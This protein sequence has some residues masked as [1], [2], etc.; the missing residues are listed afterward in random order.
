MNMVNT[1]T[2]VSPFQLHM[3]RSPHVL[4][5]ILACPTTAPTDANTDTSKAQQVLDRIGLDVR[6]A[7]D[8]LMLAKVF[9][10]DQA[11]R[12]RGQEEVY[13]IGDKVML[14]MAN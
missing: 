12:Y 13:K 10:V 11:N 4:P 14:S 8:N 5:P 9:Q 1:S 6:E 7:K 3:G 2:K